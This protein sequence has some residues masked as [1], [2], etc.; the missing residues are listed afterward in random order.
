ML[1]ASA[2]VPVNPRTADYLR[3]ARQA[4]LEAWVAGLPEEVRPSE[5]ASDPLQPADQLRPRPKVEASLFWLV[6]VLA[7]GAVA[8]GL[9]WGSA[10]RDGLAQIVK[11]L[12]G[13]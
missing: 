5:N 9:G 13:G 8:V 6:A 3:S 1:P 12:L 11:S 7:G 4:E 10:I 2:R